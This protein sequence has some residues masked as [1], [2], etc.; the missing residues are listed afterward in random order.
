MSLKNKTINGILWVS[1]SNILMKFINFTITIILARLL[2]PS[3]FG[4]VAIALI[5]VNLVESFRDLGIGPALIHRKEDRDIAANTAL[6]I[7]PAMA[8]IFYAVT[9]FIAPAAAVFFRDADLEILIRVL[10]LT[11]VIWSFGSLPRTLLTKDLEFKKQ[12]IPQLLPRISYGA[13][14]IVMALQGYGVWSLVGGQLVLMVLNVITIWKA[15]DWKPSLRFDTR[16]ALELLSYG[17]HVITASIIIFLLSVVDVTF[18][19]R[20]LGSRELGYYSIAF[21]IAGLFTFQVSMLLSQVM[22]PAFSRLQDDMDKMGSAYLKTLRYL[23]LLAFPAALGIITV[24]WYFIK[25]VYGDK[26][27]PAV[28]VLQ[29]L[30]LYGLN[31]A[32]LRTTES[33]YLAAGKP[34]IMTKINLFQFILMLILIYPL[35]LKYGIVGTGIAAV[36]PSAMMVLLTF[37]EAGKIIDKSLLA[38]VK[39]IA[40]AAAGSL[41]M[42]SLVL[43]LQ[44]F[45][46]HLS[47][48]L[49]LL[50]SIGLG[51]VSYLV[52]IWSTQKDEIGEI[53]RLIEGAR[54]L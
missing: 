8:I 15:L 18:I 47:P 37:H 23:S 22:F 41:I 45:I 51:A 1:L 49:V 11:F 17:K 29:V 5:F 43:L 3:D 24:A 38:I 2:E 6:Y 33:L 32:L 42:V 54:D 31:K 48:A 7:F 26:W 27:L 30:C 12:V 28:A 20:L 13:I 46:S 34:R 16:I 4:L 40:P 25:V 52:F 19:G 10:S 36:I 35:T 21:G 14:A 50:L 9:Y 53:R 39:H 44:Q